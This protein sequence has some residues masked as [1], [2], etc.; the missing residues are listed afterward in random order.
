[1]AADQQGAYLNRR[2]VEGVA[3]QPKV[4]FIVEALQQLKVHAQVDGA[5][6]R[7]QYAEDVP[8]QPSSVHRRRQMTMTGT[9]RS[10]IGSG[11]GH[12]GR[13]P[14]P[15]AGRPI[16]TNE[17][18]SITFRKKNASKNGEDITAADVTCEMSESECVAFVIEA[19][20]L[21]SWAESRPP[22]RPRC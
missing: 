2:R 4:A 22:Q 10:G 20:A 3:D 9:T 11:R 17:F 18:L 19:T 16:R 5:A 15:S 13:R 6:S 14:A 8:P 1:M 7:V 12:V 21:Q